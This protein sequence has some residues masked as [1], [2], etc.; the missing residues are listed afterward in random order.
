MNITAKAP[1]W[2]GSGFSDLIVRPSTYSHVNEAF[3]GCWSADFTLGE[4]RLEAE[5]WLEEGLG[6]HV[7][8]RNDQGYVRWSGFVNSVKVTVEGLTV[9]R[10]PLLDTV[11]QLVLIWSDVDPTPSPSTVGLP[12]AVTVNNADSQARWSVL[13]Q[14]VDG[15]EGTPSEGAQ[16]ANAYLANH[17]VPGL[18]HHLTTGV[19]GLS[20]T[21]GCLGYVHYLRYP[22]TFTAASGE[23]NATDKVDLVLVGHPNTSWLTFDNANVDVNTIQVK[24]Y[25]DA[26]TPGLDVIRDVVAQGGSGYARWLFGVYPDFD[27]RY[28]AAPTGYEYQRR[29]SDLRGKT[30]TLGG[31]EVDPIDVMPG[32]WLLVSDLLPG[33]EYPPPDIHDDPRSMFIESVTYRMPHSAE[34]EGGTTER[35]TAMPSRLGLVGVS[36]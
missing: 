11:N 22:F 34:M 30:E 8:T 3:G 31:V 26:Y 21:V 28:H 5:S 24:L 18:T 12:T 35:L 29:L 25:E 36:A 16:N 33:R 19:G 7:E 20:V 14:A 17:K 2:L 10:G 23:A 32:K 9:T 13:A 1:L 6:R 4:G 27:V 15:G